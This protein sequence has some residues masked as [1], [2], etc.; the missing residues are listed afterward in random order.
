MKKDYNEKRKVWYNACE[1]DIIPLRIP[2]FVMNAKSRALSSVGDIVCPQDM[3]YAVHNKPQ[4]K[5]EVWQRNMR[6]K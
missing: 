6:L 5:E 3:G 1:T 2:V 4:N